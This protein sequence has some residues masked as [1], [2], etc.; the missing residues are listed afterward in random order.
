MFCWALF[1]TSR[2]CC[3]YLVDGAINLKQLWAIQF[4]EK[5]H[6]HYNTVFKNYSK[7]HIWVFQFW[8]FP[9]IFVFLKLTCLVTLIDRKLKVFKNSPKWT[10]FGIFEWT[11]VHSKCKRSSLR[12]QCWMRL[13]LWFSNTVQRFK[14]APYGLTGHC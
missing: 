11:F 10:I 7:C 9:P 14:C 13:F 5:Y 8:H 12:S 2:V 1:V 4:F 3:S 6:H